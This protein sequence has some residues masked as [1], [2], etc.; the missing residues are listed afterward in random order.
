MNPTDH[1]SPRDIVPGIVP[2][3]RE[4]HLGMGRGTVAPDTLRLWVA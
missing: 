1:H 3:V 2:R 4:V